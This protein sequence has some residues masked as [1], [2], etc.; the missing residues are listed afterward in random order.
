MRDIRLYTTTV[1]SLLAA[2]LP[3]FSQ[4]IDPTVEVSRTYQGKMIEVHKPVLEMQIPDSVTRFDLD[5]DYSVFD[6]PYRGT[7]EFIPYVQDLKPQP[8]AWSGRR[9]F[10]RAGAGYPLHPVFDLVWSPDFKGKFRM[11]VYAEHRSYIG[12][13]RNISPVADAGSGQVCLDSPK[14]GAGGW[15]G[16]DFLTRAGVNGR[17]NWNRGLFT[18]D[19]GYYGLAARDTSLSRGYNALDAR[20]RVRSNDNRDRYFFYDIA[21]DYRYGADDL[22][23]PLLTTCDSGLFGHEFSFA[24]YIGPVFSRQQRLAVGLG[25]DMVSYAGIFGTDA[26]RVVVNPVYSLDKGRWNLDL[27]VKFSAM[28]HGGLPGLLPEQNARKGQY[29]YPDVSVGFEAVR[30]HLE[31]YADIGGG[32]KIGRYSDLLEKSHFIHPLYTSGLQTPLLENTV[33]RV[34]AALGFRGNISSRFSY[35]LKAGYRNLASA[36]LYAVV[37]GTGNLAD[38]FFTTMSYTGFQ[39]FYASLD[40][41]WKSADFSLDG[42]FTW[43]HTD[44]QEAGTLITARN[45]QMAFFAPAG[46]SGDIR[47]VYNWRRRVYAG[48]DCDFSMARKSTLC[49][50]AGYADVGVYVEVRATGLVSF[51]VRGGNLLDM[52][53]QRTP[54]YAESGINFTAGICLNL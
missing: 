37:S 12:K 26:G 13:Y 7:D 23:S 36:P 28:F 5:F 40:Y 16:C 29:V 44:M 4:E 30:N 38:G 25:L 24:S 52:T 18:F 45:E 27:G 11:G 10:V 46:F 41:G 20:L 22:E 35:D 6:S 49:S 51:W 15:N 42:N 2:A 47:A 39:M 34:S 14:G 43:R 54:M 21:L 19:V 32:E 33:E 8:G 53:V 17:L 50:L 3:A 31:L 9:L 1:I 48:A